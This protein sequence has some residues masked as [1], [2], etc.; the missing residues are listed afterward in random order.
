MQQEISFKTCSDKQHK[1]YGSI[2]PVDEIPYDKFIGRNGIIL[3][4]C[5]DCRVYHAD[6]TKKT[7]DK[8]QL[9]KKEDASKISI[10][11][12]YLQCVHDNHHLYGSEY[13]RNKV[14]R[15][16][17]INDH[18]GSLLRTCKHCRL[19]SNEI[20][21]GIKAS[22]REK[23]DTTQSNYLCVNCN[24][25]RS[26]EHCNG[27]FLRSKANL[28]KMKNS[29]HKIM[30][31]RIEETGYC[32]A[33]CK[34]AWVKKPDNLPGLDE[35][36]TLE[37]INLDD[38][39]YSNLEWDHLNK[40]EQLQV[41]GEFRGSKTANVS[42][43]VGYESKKQESRKCQLVCIACHCRITTYRY[44]LNPAY[45]PFKKY[46][47]NIDYVT[48]EKLRIGNCSICKITVDPTNLSYFQYDHID[49][50]IK[51]EHISKLV[52]NNSLKTVKEEIVKCRLLC[53]FCHRIHTSIQQTERRAEKRRKVAIINT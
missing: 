2:Y 48:S 10:D 25:I 37:G 40:E 15:E 49:P 50:E 24:T 39:E 35:R 3:Q 42:S 46:Q 41:F 9:Q 47:S 53:A 17:F 6:A 21:N 44:T 1:Y 8:K 16:M 32:C 29:S 22:K 38:I 52:R 7:K 43:I 36:Q 19:R 34:K 4:T 33:I 12:P 51:V 26:S 5:K 14:P 28:E 11:S 30:R 31:E 27:C 23:V 20:Q 18:N 13:H 45:N